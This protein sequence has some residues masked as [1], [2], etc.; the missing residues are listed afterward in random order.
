[1]VTVDGVTF[2]GRNADGGSV[3]L[4]DGISFSAKAGEITAIIGPSGGGKS[5]LIRLIN[6]LTEPSGGRISV[7][8]VDIGTMDPLQLR[9]LVALVPQKPFMFEGTVLDN[10]QMPFRYRHEAGPAAQS[11]EVAEVLTLAR[12]DR[13]L[14]ERDARSLSLGQQQ[15]VG[16][17]RALITKPQVLLLDEPTSALDRRT[18]DEL[19]A[20]LREICH[21]RNLTMIMVTHDLRL[22]E[23]VADYC[24][25]LEAGRILEQGRAAELLAHPVTAELKRFLSEPSGQE[26]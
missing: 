19:A 5:T 23:K 14:L 4:L 13:E 3:K 15:R 11:A 9:R 16:V 6:R 20:T 7:A 12:L 26:G 10:L 22:T 17:A 2:L 8:G 21:G 1:M 25:Y 24:F 18:S